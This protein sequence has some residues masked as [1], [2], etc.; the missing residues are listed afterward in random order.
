MT[1]HFS[2]TSI[3]EGFTTVMHTYI[4]HCV[5]QFTNIDVSCCWI[6]HTRRLP[7]QLVSKPRVVRCCW[8]GCVLLAVTVKAAMH[9]YAVVGLNT[10][11]VALSACSKSTCFQS[12]C[13]AAAVLLLLCCCWSSLWLWCSISSNTVDNRD[14]CSCG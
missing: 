7:S 9:W 1:W 10:Q 14:I 13:A 12:W 5:Y 11:A 4:S 8:S 3:V 2:Y 6:T